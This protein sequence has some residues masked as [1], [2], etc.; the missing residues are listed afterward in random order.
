MFELWRLHVSCMGIY[1]FGKFQNLTAGGDEKMRSAKLHHSH[2]SFSFRLIT[3]TTTIISTDIFQ[4]V[5]CN[6]ILCHSFRSLS[7]DRSMAPCGGSS[8]HSAM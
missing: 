1:Y 6:K 5:L 7:C 2:Y 3:V 4:S 8:P